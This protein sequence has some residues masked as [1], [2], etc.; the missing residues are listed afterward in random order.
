MDGSRWTIAFDIKPASG[1][2]FVM[3]GLPGLIHSGDD[4]GVNAAGIVITETTITDFPATI[5][6]ASL[7]CP[8]PQGHAVLRFD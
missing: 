7:N 6:T 4:F 5:S 8:R 1:Y 2:R 3:D